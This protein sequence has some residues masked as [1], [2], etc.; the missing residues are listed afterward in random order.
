MLSRRLRTAPLAIALVVIAIGGLPTTAAV[1]AT[2]A[3]SSALVGGLVLQ[4]DDVYGVE[5]FRPASWESTDQGIRRIYKAEAPAVATLT[6]S[7]FQVTAALL[8]RAGTYDAAYEMFHGSGNLRGWLRA[9]EGFW[10]SNVIPFQLVASDAALAAYVLRPADGTTSIVAY[11]VSNGQPLGLSL[12]MDGAFDVQQ[13]AASGIIADVLTM[14]RSA[15]ATYTGPAP[16]T[17]EAAAG[18]L[19]GPLA[20]GPYY[21]DSGNMT[22]GVFTTRM[23]TTYYQAP[24]TVYM[25]YEY[26]NYGGPTYFNAWLYRADITDYPELDCAQGTPILLS[27]TIS[28]VTTSTNRTVT[29][30]W[31]PNTIVSHL[32]PTTAH[33]MVYGDAA[34]RLC[35]PYY[36]FTH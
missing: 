11:V 34:D 26:M 35:T 14:A 21:G 19:V 16:M 2:P 28:K 10:S 22:Y 6:I 8:A 1:A 18:S 20:A 30:S 5:T 25:M 9:A 32:N 24:P 23:Q 4:K 12:E 27:H 3:A 29:D 31:Y 13:L 15:R 17:N 33:M 7:N 36:P